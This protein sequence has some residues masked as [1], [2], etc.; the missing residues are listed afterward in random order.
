MSDR[1]LSSRSDSFEDLTQK[2]FQS[3]IVDWWVR[4][5]TPPEVELARRRRVFCGVDP[6]DDYLSGHWALR[7]HAG[8]LAPRTFDDAT[9]G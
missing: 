2:R 4:S 7:G 3:L 9:P 1:Q 6:L 5:D 8:S